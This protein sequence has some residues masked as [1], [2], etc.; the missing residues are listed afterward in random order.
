M[1]GRTRPACKSPIKCAADHSAAETGAGDIIEAEFRAIDD[2]LGG[3]PA[4]A[5]C[6]TNPFAH[7]AGGETRGVA[8][9]QR[10]ADA[11]GFQRAADVVAIAARM[12]GHSDPKLPLY[13]AREML[14]M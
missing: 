1:N 3:P 9:Q 6:R 8:R 5:D 11:D 13:F 12:V 4:A 14:P 7:V 2:G 10:I